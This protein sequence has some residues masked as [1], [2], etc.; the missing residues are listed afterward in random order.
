[1]PIPLTKK[2]YPFM[3]SSKKIASIFVKNFS[4][5]SNALLIIDAQYD[6]CDPKGSLYVPG[7]EKDMTNLSQFIKNNLSKIDY[8]CL[9]M[10]SHPYVHISHPCYWVSRN[11]F[12][13]EPF[14]LITSEDVK[15]QKWIPQYQPEY[16]LEYLIKLEEQG[17]FPHVI[18]PYHCIAGTYGFAIVDTLMEAVKEWSFHSG[19]AHHIELKGSNP[20]TEH[21]GI[22]TANI[23]I[24]TDQST[25][26]NYPL[27]HSLNRF[28][29]IF[30][31]GEA[32]SH[33]VATSLKQIIELMPEMANKL[34]ILEDCMSDVI[35][36]AEQATPIYQNAYSLGSSV[37]NSK[38]QI[39]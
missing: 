2:I 39:S 9:T 14:T 38:N 26:P 7:A 1:M 13:P 33:C 5:S 22:F 24:E 20:F 23:P 31:A 35:G 11:G 18:W 30:I 17:Q 29:K 21:F 25:Q 37:F 16:S 10:D 32:R 12:H 6:F 36:F 3:V 28:D 8:I 4:M 19:K 27:L 15:S 34:V